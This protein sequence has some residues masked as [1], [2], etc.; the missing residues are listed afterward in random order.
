MSMRDV[1]CWSMQFFRQNELLNNS[2][3]RETR[4]YNPERITS[5]TRISTL[6]EQRLSYPSEKPAISQHKGKPD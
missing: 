1:V 5:Q 3:Y 4:I 2:F 6:P